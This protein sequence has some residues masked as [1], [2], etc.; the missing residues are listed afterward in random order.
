[1]AF[2]EELIA[3]TV[4]DRDWLLAAPVIDRALTGQITRETYLA[5][6][7]QAYHHVRHTVPLLMAVGS[8][9]EDRH[10]WLQPQVLHYLEE[11]AGHEQWILN[12]IDA[13][14]G[15]SA[16]A[17]SSEPSIATE[18]MVAYAY[19]TV[20]RR[21]P[22]GFFGMVLVL[23][24]TSV[25]L[26]LRAADRIQSALALP[27]RAFTYLRS[28]GSLDQEHV[29][30]LAGI[31]NRLDDAADRTAVLRCARGVYR[32][33]GEMFRGLDA[34]EDDRSGLRRIA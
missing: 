27:N 6:L 5:F 16:S 33:Y 29:G 12:D 14:G 34:R 2:Y 3:A 28:H 13:A 11:E 17:A 4:A 1:M 9:L 7:T 23:E 8:R 19:D 21:N 20:T 15:I 18:A 32:L 10:A 31:V 24:G 26:A 22:V 25:A 30:H